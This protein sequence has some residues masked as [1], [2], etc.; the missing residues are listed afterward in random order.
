MRLLRIL[1]VCYTLL[2]LSWLEPIAQ[3][4][5]SLQLRQK[6]TRFA[7]K[8]VLVDAHGNTA[9]LEGIR[10]PVD[11]P[12]LRKEAD[13]GQ[14][15]SQAL[16]AKLLHKGELGVIANKAEAYKWA[17]VAA[18]H[19]QAEAKYLLGEFDLFM[20][21]KEKADGKALAAAYLARPGQR[22]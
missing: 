3:G 18:S 7:T 21:E 12:K 16:L 5:E 22:D 17:F 8:T 20:T 1:A 6:E 13:A 11:V 9:T 4:Q 19:G 10:G 2:A 15:E 14:P